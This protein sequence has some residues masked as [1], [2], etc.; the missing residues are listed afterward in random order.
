MKK[1]FAFVGIAVSFLSCNNSGEEIPTPTRDSIVIEQPDTTTKVSTPD[2]LSKKAGQPV[3]KKKPVKK[4]KSRK[5]AYGRV[6]NHPCWTKALD[7]RE[8]FNL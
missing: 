6:E 5:K 8:P 4:P 2:T 3:K 1:F 7:D